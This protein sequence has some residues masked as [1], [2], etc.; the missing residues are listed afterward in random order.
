MNFNDQIKSV[1][2]ILD[3]QAVKI[4][5][6]KLKALG[7]KNRLYEEEASR[8]SREQEIKQMIKEKR[9]ELDRLKFQYQSLL[10]IENEQKMIIEK[11]SNND[12]NYSGSV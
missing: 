4:E 12:E 9:Q 10:K 7:K 11:L 8:E 6:E 2:D 5:K 3:N 1:N